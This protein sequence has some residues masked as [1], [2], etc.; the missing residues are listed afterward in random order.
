MTQRAF[1]FRGLRA[2]ARGSRRYRHPAGWQAYPGAGR[3]TD[4]AADVLHTNRRRRLH[5]VEELEGASGAVIGRLLV[6]FA[7]KARDVALAQGTCSRRFTDLREKLV[8]AG[9]VVRAKRGAGGEPCRERPLS[10]QAVDKAVDRLPG[11]LGEGIAHHPRP[12][13]MQRITLRI[14]QVAAPWPSDRCGHQALA[15]ADELRNAYVAV[16]VRGRRLDEES[17][18]ELAIHVSAEAVTR[19]SV[20]T[21]DVG[22]QCA[23]AAA[24]LETRDL[25]VRHLVDARLLFRLTRQ[26][27]LHFI[28]AARHLKV[29]LLAITGSEGRKGWIVHHVAVAERIDRCTRTQGYCRQ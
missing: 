22:G 24:C 14:D 9:C 26:E 4:R 13:A 23:Y 7:T 17:L 20:R 6:D 15:A 28:V 18:A 19:E 2:G 10:G 21:H 8:V 1:F 29:V 3:L 12:V 25:V 11:R 5:P 27:E 16:H